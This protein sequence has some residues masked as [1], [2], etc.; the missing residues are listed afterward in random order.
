MPSRSLRMLWFSLAAVCCLTLIQIARIAPVQAQS[1]AQ[2]FDSR[3]THRIAITVTNPSGALVNQQVRI[4][5]D[6]TFPFV[7]AADDGA[8][9]RVTASDGQTLL[10]FWIERWQ[11]PTAATLWAQLPLIAAGETQTIYL[12]YGNPGASSLSNASTVFEF[13]NGFDSIQIDTPLANGST[14]QQTP[15]YDGSGQVVNPDI[16][17]FPNGWKGYRYWLTLE[18]YPASQDSYENPSVLVSNDGASW[19]PPPGITNPIA[20]PTTSYLADADIIYDET[21]DQLWMYYPHQQVNDQTLMVRK[22]AS[23]GINWGGQYDEPVI[24]SAPDFELLSPAVVKV[25]ATYKMWS[26]NSGSVGCDGQAN[27]VQLRTSSD[28][29]NWSAPSAVNLTI[30]GVIPWHIDV[31]YVPSKAQYWAVMPG[32]APGS[33]C[34]NTE[35]YFATSPDG[36]NWTTYPAPALR[37]GANWDSG[38][39]YRA[40]LLYDDATDRLR[41]WYS[42]NDGTIWHQGYTERDYSDFLQVLVGGNGSTSNGSGTWQHST[43]QVARGVA[44]GKF[45]QT[46]GADFSVSMPHAGYTGFVQEWE[47]YDNLDTSAKD[48]VGISSSEDELALGVSTDVSTGYYVWRDT[49]GQVTATNVARTT[50]WHTFGIQLKRTASPRFS[51]TAM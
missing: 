14:W 29:I 16:A 34:V 24:F 37:K 27:V 18:P 19:A 46:S 28:G 13:Y 26:V 30:S 15:T 12:Y 8:D 2:W 36:V 6:S 38:Q 51:S 39:I 41:I 1:S 11:R 33:N 9:L 17:Y 40:T 25:G 45:T 48:M 31:I 50:G 44:A 49:A 23:D 5:L 32:Y 42:A 47:L 20:L 22:T 4:P 7:D 43:Q 3:W 35:L 10:P 21:S